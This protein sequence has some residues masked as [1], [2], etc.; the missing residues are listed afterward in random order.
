VIAKVRRQWRAFGAVVFVLALIL[1]GLVVRAQQGET[2]SVHYSPNGAGNGPNARTETTGAFSA[3]AAS[4]VVLTVDSNDPGWGTKVDPALLLGAYYRAEGSATVLQRNWIAATPENHDTSALIVLASY[5][6]ADEPELVETAI[7]AV[8]T[9]PNGR[10]FVASSVGLFSTY[11]RAEATPQRAVTGSLVSFTPT[12]DGVAVRYRGSSRALAGVG[13]VGRDL[14]WTG[15]QL[16]GPAI[17]ATRPCTSADFAADSPTGIEAI[18]DADGAFGQV[19]VNLPSAA[20]V[21]STPSGPVTLTARDSGGKVLGS[22]TSG[23]DQVTPIGAWNTTKLNHVV[24]GSTMQCPVDSPVY[25]YTITTPWGRQYSARIR[26]LF[27][28]VGTVQPGSAS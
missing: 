9:Q 24:I 28:T 15:S 8:S 2:P 6:Q 14:V 16:S 25:N 21:C 13:D 4:P 27:D 3:L 7:A 23:P 12:S 22:W 18:T 26:C 17:D 5:S 1:T 19:S 10:L 11:R 20:E